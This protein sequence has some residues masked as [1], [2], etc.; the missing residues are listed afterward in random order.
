MFFAGVSSPYQHIFCMS[1]MK[2]TVIRHLSFPFICPASTIVM[3]VLALDMIL[4][5]C[6]FLGG[7]SSSASFLTLIS[8]TTSPRFGSLPSFGCKS[9]LFGWGTMCMSLLCQ[10]FGVQLRHFGVPQEE[11]AANFVFELLGKC[12]LSDAE[13]T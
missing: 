7:S 8:T 9:M 2:E 6:A 13:F 12:R 3:D 11:I 4:C 5:S 1:S 10:V